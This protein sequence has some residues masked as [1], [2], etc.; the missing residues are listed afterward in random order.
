VL[1]DMS[2]VSVMAAY[3]ITIYIIECISWTIKYLTHTINVC[4]T[5]ETH[6]QYQ[7]KQSVSQPKSEPG[8]RPSPSNKVEALPHGPRNAVSR[9]WS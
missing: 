2:V 7:S 5:E 1:V 6:E 4:K 9:K 3:Y 8:V